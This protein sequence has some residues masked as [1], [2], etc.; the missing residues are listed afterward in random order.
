MKKFYFIFLMLLFVSAPAFSI[1]ESSQMT[2][3]VYY[4]NQNYSDEVV[5]L[6]DLQKFDPYKETQI[7]EK[8]KNPI[9]KAVRAFF[10]YIDP[11]LDDGR[12]GHSNEIKFTNNWKEP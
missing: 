2:D 1:I 5:R 9:V 12:Y 4:K 10:I 7:E 3:K 8:Y 6:S 11:G